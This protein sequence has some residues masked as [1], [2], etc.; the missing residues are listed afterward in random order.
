M[1]QWNSG[2]RWTLLACVWTL[3]VVVMLLIAWR[4]SPYFYWFSYILAGALGVPATLAATIF[5]MRDPACRFVSIAFLNLV[6]F[7][8]LMIFG[9]KYLLS[10]HW[11]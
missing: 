11:A 8:V 1:N 6:M 7:T 4:V 3:I 9:F 2:N 5:A 10:I